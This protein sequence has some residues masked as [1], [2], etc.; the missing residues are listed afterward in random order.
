VALPRKSRPR[1]A[2]GHEAIAPSFAPRGTFRHAA[3]EAFLTRLLA[4]CLGVGLVLASG[5][6][7]G[8]E[9]AAAGDESAVRRQPGLRP[10]SSDWVDALQTKGFWQRQSPP[11]AAS[12]PPAGRAGPEPG[13]RS[14]PRRG[15]Q[16]HSSYRTVCVRLC[17]GYYWP[18]GFATQR[19]FLLRDQEKCER[20][21]EAPVQLFIQPSPGGDPRDLKSLSGAAYEDLGSA[22]LY[23]ETY[24]PDCRCRAD[25]WDPQETARHDSYRRDGAEQGSGP[26][27]AKAAARDHT[28]ARP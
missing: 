1:A 2:S 4:A 23:R 24:D 8:N 6:A 17:D 25:P 26:A 11:P 22:Y 15:A 10:T 13:R 21:C 27:A 12:A 18:M 7:S 28:T 5:R 14:P 20:S 19:K 9:E 16:S 3:P